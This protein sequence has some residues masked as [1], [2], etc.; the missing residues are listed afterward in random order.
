MKGIGQIVDTIDRRHVALLRVS[1]LLIGED[2][3]ILNELV[4]F[5]LSHMRAY[6]VTL[7]VPMKVGLAGVDVDLAP[8]TRR[9]RNAAANGRPERV[10]PQLGKALSSLRTCPAPGRTRDVH[11]SGP[12]TYRTE[13]L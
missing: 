2:H 9:R 3:E 10:P 13:S 8:F 6:Q 11:R 1:H 12:A 4:A 7:M 5:H